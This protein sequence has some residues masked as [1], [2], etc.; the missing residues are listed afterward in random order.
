[1]LLPCEIG[2]RIWRLF[3]N[4][5]S[6]PAPHWLITIDMPK[7]LDAQAIVIPTNCFTSKQLER[8]PLRMTVGLAQ[9]L[10]SRLG[11]VQVLH[12]K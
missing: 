2:E 4:V 1:M 5:P 8:A 12:L 10:R 6:S 7:A 9:F 11:W 3:D